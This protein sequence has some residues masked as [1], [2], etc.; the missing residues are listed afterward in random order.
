MKLKRTITMLPLLLCILAAT[1]IAGHVVIL[2]DSV[3][4]DPE[5]GVH[6]KAQIFEADGTVK[7]VPLD[8]YKWSVIPG[9]LG[10]IS[11][12]G[13]FIAGKQA[14][15]G[16]VVATISMDGVRSVGEA[17]VWVGEQPVPPIK[18]VIKPSRAIVP[19]GDTLQVKAYAVNPAGRN[20]LIDYVRWSV[21]PKNLGVIDQ[22]GNFI[23]N[24]AMM[25][26]TII[27][28]AEIAGQKYKDEA[29]IIVSEKPTGVIK[30]TVSAD[31]NATPIPDASL[32]ACRI[33]DIKWRR[34]AKSDENGNYTL[35][36]LIPGYYVIY[37]KANHFIP[38]WHQDVRKFVEAKPEMGRQRGYF[39]NRFWIIRRSFD[40]GYSD[41]GSR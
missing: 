20:V 30:G 27:T 29:R 3:V 11:E 40:C 9:S 39:D 22:K 13:Y 7:R 6:F 4:L 23:A 10:E 12:D 21:Y 34:F 17:D 14:G 35:K 41:S 38:E 18:L 28:I 31:E 37:A 24:N 33:G 26:G 32:L 16:K 25:E 5:H 19:P 1:S 2:P 8:Q 15:M 36:S